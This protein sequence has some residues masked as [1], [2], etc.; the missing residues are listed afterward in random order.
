M[1]QQIPVIF[2]SVFILPYSCECFSPVRRYN[3]IGVIS[4][5]QWEKS[6]AWY[7]LLHAP[8]SISY[9][10]NCEWNAIDEMIKMHWSRVNINIGHKHNKK[11]HSNAT[12]NKPYTYTHTHTLTTS[13]DITKLNRADQYSILR[14]NS[15]LALLSLSLF[16]LCSMRFN[17]IIVHFN[18]YCVVLL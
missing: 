11:T 4:Q 7:Q 13:I 8:I 17:S 18:C 10:M 9:A 15:F 5:K 12:T 14:I 3:W 6:A 1:A 16:V 2:F